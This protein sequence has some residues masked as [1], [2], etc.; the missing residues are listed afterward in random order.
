[1]AKI[2]NFQLNSHLKYFMSFQLFEIEF[3]FLQHLLRTKCV[4]IHKTFKHFAVPC[5]KL[6]FI[7]AR[8]RIKA[9]KCVTL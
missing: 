5:D 2:Q 7:L 9:F 4:T 3:N 6:H 8:M 1:M